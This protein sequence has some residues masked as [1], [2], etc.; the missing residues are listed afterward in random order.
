MV[1]VLAAADEK[2]AIQRAFGYLDANLPRL[3]DV[4]GT[5]RKPFTYAVAGLDYLMRGGSRAGRSPLDGITAHLFRYLDEVESRTANPANLPPRH[6]LAS[7]RYI[8][9]YT[10]PLSVMGLYFAELELRGRSRALARKGMRRVLALLVAAQE[11]NGG[12]GHGRIN[13]AGKL[14]GPLANMKMGGYPNTLVSSSNCVA[15]CEDTSVFG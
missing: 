13:A 4:Q 12:W 3:P 14:D 9:Q 7:S 1:A 5:P 11:P 10:W 2:K 6:G 8:V 15:I